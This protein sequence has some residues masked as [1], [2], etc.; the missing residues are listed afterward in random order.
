MKISTCI[1]CDEYRYI[2]EKG[3]CRGCATKERNAIGGCARHRELL[4]KVKTF[5]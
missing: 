5:F 1:G 2:E 4:K 3:K